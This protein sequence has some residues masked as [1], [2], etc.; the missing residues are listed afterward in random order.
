MPINRPFVLTLSGHDPSGGAGIQADLEAIISHQCR[1]VSVITALTAQDTH[2]VSKLIPQLPQD[3]LQQANL[4]MA[5]VPVKVFKI[6]LLGHVE[7]VKTI[8][9]FLQQF[10][11]IPAVF[12]PVL[13]A[14]GG[15]NLANNALI[16][17]INEWLLAKVTVLTPN[18]LEA[19]KLTGLNYI[20]DCGV[21]LSKSG[22][23]YVLITGAHEDS[24]EVINQLYHDGD[25]IQRYTWPRLPHSY[26]GSGCTLAASIAALMARGLTVLDAIAEAQQYTWNALS[27]GFQP[28]KGQYL[29]DRFFWLNQQC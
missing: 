27:S 26:H 28:G 9:T 8:Y 25:C 13:A 6:G 17:A 18:S 3:I 7:T 14:G 2:N 11:D 23:R 21:Q 4:L 15:Q 22:C 19:R 24:A 10:P 16:N 20:H 5:D 1:P 29:P 12:D